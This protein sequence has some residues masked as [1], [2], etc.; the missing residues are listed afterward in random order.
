MGTFK[1]GL[2]TPGRARGAD[3]GSASLPG[4][5][6]RWWQAARGGAASKAN[7][8]AAGRAFIRAAR[9]CPALLLTSVWRPRRLHVRARGRPCLKPSV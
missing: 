8:S 1:N 7:A 2:E 9:L 4:R 3:A 5:P 6:R